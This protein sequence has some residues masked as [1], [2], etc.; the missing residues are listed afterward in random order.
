MQRCNKQGA[1]AIIHAGS[2]GIVDLKHSQ[3]QDQNTYI[4]K[5]VLF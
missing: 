1:R 4:Y 3:N 2:S 5:E